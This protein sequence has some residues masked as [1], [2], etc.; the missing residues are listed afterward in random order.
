MRHKVIE[1]YHGRRKWPFA[2][3][4]IGDTFRYPLDN[5]CARCLQQTIATAARSKNYRSM[6]FETKRVD[7]YIECKRIA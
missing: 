7:S 2:E 3:M 6:C 4:A 1:Q 5:E